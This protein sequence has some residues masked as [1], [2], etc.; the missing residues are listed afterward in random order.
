MV[1]LVVFFIRAAFNA[2]QDWSF[3]LVMTSIKI[4]LSNNCL[5]LRDGS[6][7]S[8]LA[9]EIVLGDILYIK[10][11]DKLPVEVR[12]VEISTDVKFD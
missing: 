6:Q 8:V 12:F 2:W 1:L 9:F 10:S 5:V 4:M 11:R 7:V 3:F